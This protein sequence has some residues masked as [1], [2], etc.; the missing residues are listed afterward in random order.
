MFNALVVQHLRWQGATE[1]AL[2]QV[3]WARAE[4]LWKN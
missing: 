4:P 3:E 2:S 1:H